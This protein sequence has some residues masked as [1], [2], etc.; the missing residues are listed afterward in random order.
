MEKIIITAAITGSIHTPTM[1]QYL[2]VTPK[3]IADNAVE[4]AEAGAAIVHLHARNPSTGQPSSDQELFREA[5]T[6]IKE[7]SDVVVNITTGGAVTMST[8]ERVK[9]VPAFKPEMTSLNLG[10]MNFGLFP[11]GQKN[12][13]WKFDWEKSYL[14]GT[15]DAVFKNTFSDISY[16]CK[17]MYENESK[18]ELECYDSGHIYNLKQL[19]DDGVVRTPCHVQFVLGVL[20]GIGATPEDFIHMKNTADKLIGPKNFTYSVCAAGRMEFTLCLLAAALGGHVR[21]GLEDNLYLAR[22]ILAKN[23]AELVQK[24][25]RLVYEVTGREAATPIEAREILALKGR[26]KT[27]Y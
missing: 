21:V 7:R 15:R 3:Q 6:S 9:M 10:S 22:G 1:S 25:K 11:M 18:P 26:A 2:P 19:I 13:N 20:G 16:F 14:E 27:N 17:T 24:I 8:A 12:M 23:N 4:A 5:L